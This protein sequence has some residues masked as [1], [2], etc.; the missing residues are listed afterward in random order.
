MAQFLDRSNLLAKEELE[1]KRVDLGKGGY[2]FV[3]Q[4]TGRERNSFEQTLFTEKIDADG[5]VELVR[6][7]DDFRAKLAVH[8]VCDEQGNLILKP[9]DVETLSVN[10][11]A[12][13]LTKI[14][15]VATELN[16]I[17]SEDRKKLEKN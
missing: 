1:I 7:Q 6:N 9:E 4:M 8:T 12:A 10:I 15:D 13:R 5:T 14:A 17:S 16:R 2:V 11:S 3:R